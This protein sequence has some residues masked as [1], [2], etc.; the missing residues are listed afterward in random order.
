MG[1]GR[2]RSNRDDTYGNSQTIRQSSRGDAPTIFRGRLKP[3]SPTVPA[4]SAKDEKKNDNDEKCLSV[5]DVR[6]F[7]RLDVVPALRGDPLRAI[8]S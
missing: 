3:A 1:R 2:T 4:P 7:Q 8:S 5:H 6:P